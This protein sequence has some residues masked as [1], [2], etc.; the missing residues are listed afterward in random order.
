ML[1]NTYLQQCA[2]AASALLSTAIVAFGSPV[3]GQAQFL[4]L[5][6][7]DPAPCA[8]NGTT[9]T[10]VNGIQCEESY[11]GDGVAG[12]GYGGDNGALPTASP[13]KS[14]LVNW[15]FEIWHTGCFKV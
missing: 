6:T 2:V 9:A 10:L 7:S 3:I 8:V 14:C 13:S 4:P 12:F 11:I 5:G 15:P 1:K